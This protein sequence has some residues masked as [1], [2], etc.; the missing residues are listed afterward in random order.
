MLPLQDAGTGSRT[1]MPC[2]PRNWPP[3]KPGV[4]RSCAFRGNE[5]E[6]TATAHPRQYPGHDLTR[7]HQIIRLL[8]LELSRE[9]GLSTI[10]EGIAAAETRFF[11]RWAARKRTDVIS[12]VLCRQPRLQKSSS[13]SRTRNVKR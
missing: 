10:A 13:H 11:S 1:S 5:G 7:L 12:A 6:T 4:F 2:W 3:P 8:D 9:F